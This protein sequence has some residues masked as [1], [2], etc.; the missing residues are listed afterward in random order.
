M[1]TWKW[2]RRWP[3]AFAQLADYMAA[4]YIASGKLVR[5]LENEGTSGMGLYVYRLSV[6]PFREGFER[7]LM[8][9]WSPLDR[10]QLC[11]DTSQDAVGTHLGKRGT[12]PR[13]LTLRL[14]DEPTVLPRVQI[15]RPCNSMPAND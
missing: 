12:E 3:I 1:P 2:E 15:G 7:Y 6:A 14:N 5:V 13:R 10:C 4:P 11:A 8:K 9:C